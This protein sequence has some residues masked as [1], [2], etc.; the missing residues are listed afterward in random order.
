MDNKII[1]YIK[2][3]Q[4]DDKKDLYATFL[5]R[6]RIEKHLTLE[7]L[8]KDVCTVSYLSRIENKVVKVDDEYFVH[9]FKKMDIDFYELKEGK[10]Y[11]IL[12]DLLK[13][14]LNRDR[15]KAISLINDALNTTYYVEIEYELMVLYDSILKELFGEAN[16]SILKLANKMEVLL[17]EE[18]ITYLFLCSYY[19]YLVGNGIYAAE[20]ILALCEMDGLSGIFRYAIYD[21]ALD[22]FVYTG[23][24]ELFFKYYNLLLEEEY[25][26]QFHQAFMRH[27]VQK[28]YLDYSIK[29]NQLDSY[30]NELK[31]AVE[32]SFLPDLEWIEL[33]NRYRVENSDKI[34]DKIDNYLLNPRIL[35]YEAL[36]VL[37]SNKN[38]Y[39]QVFLNHQLKIKF[40]FWHYPYKRICEIV[41]MIKQNLAS[42]EILNYLKELLDMEK[43]KSFERFFLDIIKIIYMEYAIKIGHYKEV[44]VKLLDIERT[45]QVLPNF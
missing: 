34:L 37:K 1:K 45:K 13:C 19:A 17:E 15:S 42:I 26:L 41:T 20:Q 4:I 9:L 31:E 28:N 3:K 7:E 43:D 8:S 18:I 38:Q 35:A 33:L 16:I 24:N 23:L 29:K 6:K 11:H 40:E 22:I 27:Q 30:Y 21:L 44:A 2:N 5:K 14:Y 12:E 36:L 39:Y 25:K 32:D 10:D